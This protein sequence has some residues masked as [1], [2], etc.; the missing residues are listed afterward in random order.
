[1]SPRNEERST[2][3]DNEKEEKQ[4]DSL[5]GL[6]AQGSRELYFTSVAEGALLS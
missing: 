1:M 3:Q 2:R 4:L 6:R 5:K